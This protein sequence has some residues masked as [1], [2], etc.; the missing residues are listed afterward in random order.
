[1][2][3][4][5]FCRNK[6]SKMEKNEIRSVIKYLCMKNFT[7]EQVNQDLRNTLGVHAL[8]YSTV[9]R[10]CAEFKRGRTSTNDDPRSGRPAT[11]VS[12][13]I[14][15]KVEKI[16]LADRRVTVRF[17]AEELK[18][19]IGSIFNIIHDHL[20]MR[21]VSARWVPRML[22]DEQKRD[23]VRI[24]RRCL[25]LIKDNPDEFLHRFVT[26]D[27]TWLHHYDPE[28]KKQSMTWKRASSPTPKK[29]K[30]VPSAGKV[31]GSFFWDSQGVIMIEYLS[32]GATI[33]G[34]VYA[35]QIKKLRCQI[36]EKRRGKLRKIVLFHQDNAPA[37]K[38]R[39]AMAAIKD[40]GFEL[41]EHPPYSPDLA[42][43]DFYLFPRLKEYLKGQKFDD[44]DAVVA[45]VQGFL[46]GQDNEFFKKGILGLEKRYTKCIHLKGDYVE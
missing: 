23:R 25:K 39:V 35:E 13:E 26:M 40:A 1:M 8:P 5:A 2:I 19:S 7:T 14:I 4:F 16:V 41:V 34:S 10:W 44:D 36:R 6:L 21:K 17:V 3:L 30:V 43:S 29:F 24:S 18:I 28:T 31:M 9:A 42:P 45:S 32:H 33:T 38:S 20:G 22:T 27:E 15:K 46:E 11:S 12:E 37:H